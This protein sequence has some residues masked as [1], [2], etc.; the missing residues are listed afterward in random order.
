MQYSGVRLYSFDS[1]DP[2]P[3]LNNTIIVTDN[4]G[5]MPQLQC[6]SGSTAP[7]V[8]QWIAPSGQDATHSTSD[9]FDVV[10]GSTN[11]PGYFNISLHPGQF[12]TFSDQGVY[13]CRIPDE[14]GVT[15]SVFVG[16]YLPALTS[17]IT[18]LTY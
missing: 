13:T 4:F 3:L 8:G 18:L 11:D 7:N 9:P 6:I 17:K 16:I 15:R 10:L 5:R 2:G 1:D 14:A 12:I